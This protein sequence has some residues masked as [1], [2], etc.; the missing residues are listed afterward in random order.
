MARHHGCH[1]VPDEVKDYIITERTSFERF[2]EQLPLLMALGSRL[3]RNLDLAGL[4]ISAIRF[5]LYALLVMVTGFCAGYLLTESLGYASAAMIVLM[6][7][8]TIIV[9]QLEKRRLEKFTGQLPE[10]LSMIS[11]SLR[12][13]HSMTSAIELVG[14]EIADPAGELLR[15]AFE[16]QKLGMRTI[17]TLNNMGER[18]ESLDL[19]F[20]ITS[21]SINSEVGGNLAEVLDKLAETIRERLNIRHKVSVIT[22]Q[23]RLSGYVLGVLPLVAFLGMTVLMPGY[24]DELFREKQ[25]QQ[26]LIGAVALQVIGFFV[27]RKIINIRI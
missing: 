18:F 16:Q 9:K 24:E 26:M 11:R 4:N 5:I 3:E 2:L 7:A 13:G 17:D 15:I 19:R 8:L 6:L 23:G 10:L 21:V 27:I 20:F 25:G 1:A 12:A 22:A 14:T